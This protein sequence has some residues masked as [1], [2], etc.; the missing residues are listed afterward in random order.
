MNGALFTSGT[1]IAYMVEG[2]LAAVAL[3]A[4]TVATLNKAS[5]E[6]AGAGI[7]NQFLVIFLA[8]MIFMSSG[9]AAL[10]THEMQSHGIKNT[11]NVPNPWGQ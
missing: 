8:A 5:K 7:T 2:L 11:V 6:G 9:I 1:G 10:V 4:G 3:V